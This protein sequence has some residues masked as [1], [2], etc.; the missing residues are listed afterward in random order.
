MHSSCTGP[1]LCG[2]FFFNKSILQ[3]CMIHNWLSLQTQNHRCGG[4]TKVTQGFSAARRVGTSNACATQGS[5]VSGQLGCQLQNLP[6]YPTY[7]IVLRLRYLVFHLPF[8]Y[9]FLRFFLMIVM[10][11]SQKSNGE[12]WHIFQC[13]GSVSLA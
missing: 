13:S 7:Y 2:F 12:I 10:L 3:Y 9:Y 1:L 4:K 8:S 6:F 11:T 5:A